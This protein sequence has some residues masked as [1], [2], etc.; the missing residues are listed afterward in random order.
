MS[1]AAEGIR[2]T[3]ST[4]LRIANRLDG[5]DES[6]NAMRSGAQEQAERS[7]LVEVSTELL[8][9]LD[10]WSAP[11][12]VKIVP[13]AGPLGWTLVARAP[14]GYIIDGKPRHPRDVT[15]SFV[16]VDPFLEQEQMERHRRVEQK[17]H[18]GT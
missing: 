4:L 1:S 7:V 5:I 15:I 17:E 2:E 3:A 12:Q 10:E 14:L 13:D 18:D 6:A 16:A 8:A 11:V 9:E